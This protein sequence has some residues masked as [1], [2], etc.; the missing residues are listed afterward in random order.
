MSFIGIE[1]EDVYIDVKSQEEADEVAAILKQAGEPNDFIRF[2]YKGGTRTCLIHGQSLQLPDVP[3]DWWFTFDAGSRTVAISVAQLAKALGVE[4]PI[5]PKF[6][7]GKWYKRDEDGAIFRFS[8]EFDT[9]CAPR[10]YGVSI[11]PWWLDDTSWGWI[12][13]FTEATH[14][15]VKGALIKCAERMGYEEGVWIEPLVNDDWRGPVAHHYEL[16]GDFKLVVHGESYAIVDEDGA[17]IFRD[18][19]WAELLEKECEVECAPE[20][21]SL[22]QL[23]NELELEVVETTYPCWVEGM[24]KFS[25]YKLPGEAHIYSTKESAVAAY[26]RGIVRELL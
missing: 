20:D 7:K 21:K 16:E 24:K 19:K 5:K 1:K 23:L 15:E 12:G 8:G 2:P 26:L 4:Y 3:S 10:G 22:R 14:D 13:D 6:E 17:I 11:S 25:C 18:G 9:C